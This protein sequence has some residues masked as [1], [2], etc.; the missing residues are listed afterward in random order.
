MAMLQLILIWAFIPSSLARSRQP[1]LS[2]DNLKRD[3]YDYQK[4]SDK[5]NLIHI[6]EATP[7]GMTIAT[8]LSPN[9][10][11]SDEKDLLVY[12]DKA[13]D[14][15]RH[16]A[17]TN[18]DKLTVAKKFRREDDEYNLKIITS[19]KD[20]NIAG[21]QTIRV[22]LIKP[23][24]TEIDGINNAERWHKRLKRN[25]GTTTPTTHTTIHSTTHHPNPTT[26]S[27]T[28]STTK[29]QNVTTHSTTRSTTRQ[30]TTRSATSVKVSGIQI[31]IGLCCLI[32]VM[33][34]LTFT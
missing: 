6:D 33:A 5:Q 9:H 13:T 23:N 28:H 22:V 18:R 11:P 2:Y 32:Y 26:H 17:I 31:A 30:T 27:T 34:S 7:V 16:F 20:G 14:P 21:S 19:D 1:P 4:N 29:H 8:I 24:E 10:L 3:D 15:V 12:I 25:I